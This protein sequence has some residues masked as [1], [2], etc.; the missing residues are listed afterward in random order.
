MIPTCHT[1]NHDINV[2]FLQSDYM[3]WSMAEAI[4]QRKRAPNFNSCKI[5]FSIKSTFSLHFND[6]NITTFCLHCRNQC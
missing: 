5:N 2:C 6:S 3:V 1:G 4:Q